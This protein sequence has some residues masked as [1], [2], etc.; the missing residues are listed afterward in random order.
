MVEQ[1][2]YDVIETLPD[3]VEIRAYPEH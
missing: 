3:G 2:R 1:Q